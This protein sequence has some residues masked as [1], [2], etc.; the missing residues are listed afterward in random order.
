MFFHIDIDVSM[1]TKQKAWVLE[2]N[3]KRT[4]HPLIPVTHSQFTQWFEYLS[5]FPSLASLHVTITSFQFTFRAYLQ[6]HV[7]K[8]PERLIIFL[9]VTTY[10]SSSCQIGMI[11]FY[12]IPNVAELKLCNLT[13]KTLQTPVDCHND[14]NNH[15]GML[16]KP[17]KLNRIS[18]TAHIIARRN[19]ISWAISLQ[20]RNSD[21]AMLLLKLQM[22]F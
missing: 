12:N 14:D 5:L 9:E 1:I 15:T 11:P 4:F 7:T 3:G 21:D 18:S 22:V 20:A 19:S 17:E 2:A 8:A 16:L 13:L 10:C 6:T